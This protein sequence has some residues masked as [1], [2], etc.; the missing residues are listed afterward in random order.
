MKSA[1]HR[2]WENLINTYCWLW[3]SAEMS[4]CFQGARGASGNNLKDKANPGEGLIWVKFSHCADRVFMKIRSQNIHAKPLETQ[5]VQL[6]FGFYPIWH[7]T[8]CF[9][10]IPKLCLR[11]C[12]PGRCFCAQRLRGSQPTGG[13]VSQGRVGSAAVTNDSSRVSVA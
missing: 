1:Q 6:D 2:I 5:A 13:R 11:I 3:L 9:K 4:D 7:F 12:K 10:N 8:N